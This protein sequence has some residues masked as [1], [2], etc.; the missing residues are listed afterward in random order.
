MK[1]ETLRKRLLDT[2]PKDDK[3]RNEQAFYQDG[4]KFLQNKTSVNPFVS[5]MTCY[6]VAYRLA[7]QIISLCEI[8]AKQLDNTQDKA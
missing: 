5:N 6:G 1:I 7:L 2:S 3:Q 8:D 4:I